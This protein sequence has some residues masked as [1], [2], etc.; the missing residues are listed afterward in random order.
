MTRE[1][2]IDFIVYSIWVLQGDYVPYEKFENYTDAELDKEVEWQEYLWEEKRE[3]ISK[4]T[5]RHSP[6]KHY[7][8]R[9][10]ALLSF[11]NEL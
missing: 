9:R 11:L 3:R 5:Q 2:N 10:T 6:T 4:T 8:K 1:E 7:T